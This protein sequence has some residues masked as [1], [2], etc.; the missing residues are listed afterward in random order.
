MT[1]MTIK[2]IKKKLEAGQFSIEE[3]ESFKQ[4]SRKGVQRIV[5]QYETKRQKR[6]ELKAQFETMKGF[7]YKAKR[8]GK[9]AIAGIDEAGRG[10]LA[11]P[12]VAGAVIL[13]DDFYLEG[14]NDSKKLSLTKR[15]S[16]YKI[17][18]EETDWGVGIVS[19]EEIDRMNIYQATKLAMMRAVEG[20]KRYPDHL[21]I[22]AMELEEVESE[23]SLVKG[24]QRSVSI[25]AASV[26]AKVTRDHYMAELH[27]SYPMYQFASNQGYGT[28]DHIDALMAH[29]PSPYHRHSFAPVR[30]ATVRSG[31]R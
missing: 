26:I 14:L 12:V 23:V 1:T 4:D 16:F 27:K 22:D 8:N 13:P 7:E 6:A 20:L 17:I 24:D 25:A 18:K 3:M 29:G 19:N 21:L 5:A 11:G 9:T 28:S 15:E 2:E 30:E 31:D 10:P